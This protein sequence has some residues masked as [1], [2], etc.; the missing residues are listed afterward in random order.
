MSDCVACHRPVEVG[1]GGREQAATRAA[2]I[3]ATRVVNGFEPIDEIV[4]VIMCDE[5]YA[6]FRAWEQK[7]MAADS[8][9][10]N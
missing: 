3:N 4:V 7:G 5:C 2:E 6:E 10:L 8:G 9:L 1:E